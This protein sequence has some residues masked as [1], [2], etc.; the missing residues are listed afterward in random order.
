MN[1]CTMLDFPMADRKAFEL[2]AP[3]YQVFEVV[4]LRKNC[5]PFFLQLLA[6]YHAKKQHLEKISTRRTMQSAI[7]LF[8]FDFL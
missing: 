4:C 3:F 7:R 6:I 2:V 8:V 5:Q 1:A